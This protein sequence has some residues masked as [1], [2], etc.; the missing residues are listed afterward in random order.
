MSTVFIFNYLSL[1]KTFHHLNISSKKLRMLIFTI[2]DR[3]YTFV[4]LFPFQF[5]G[6]L[7]KDNCNF[8]YLIAREIPQKTFDILLF[9]SRLF[10]RV[11]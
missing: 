3:L 4:N 11:V 1:V 10:V 7:A 2:N 5:I 8:P 9:K 6:T